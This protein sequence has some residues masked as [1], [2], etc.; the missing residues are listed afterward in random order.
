MPAVERREITA[1]TVSLIDLS[2]ADHQ[3]H[4]VAP[5]AVSI[6][7]AY[8]EP[9]A[10]FGAV[11]AGDEPVGF[12]MVYGDA[13]NAKYVLWRFRIDSAHQGKGYGREAMQRVI[14]HVRSRPDATELITSWVDAPESAAGFSQGIGFVPTGESRETRSSAGSHSDRWSQRPGGAAIGACVRFTRCRIRCPRRR[15][16][17]QRNG[18]GPAHP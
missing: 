12:V 2:V 15:R 13:E 11:C 8:F 16:A 14:E 3:Q 18:P 9:E 5:V 7:Q 10:W 4:L 6:A 1:G 17:Q